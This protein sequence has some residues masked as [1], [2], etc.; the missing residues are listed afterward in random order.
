MRKSSALL[1]IASWLVLSVGAIPAAQ[2]AYSDPSGRVARLSDSSGEV[3]YSPAG[4]DQWYAISRNRPLTRGDRLWADRNGRAELQFGS[5]AVRL[6]AETSFAI[7]EFDDRIAQLQIT[8]GTLNIS[9]RRLYGGQSIEVATPTLAFVI[10]RAGRYRIDVDANDQLTTIQVWE[11][12]GEAYGGDGSR[13]PLRAGDVVRFYDSDLRDYEMYALP[14]SDSFDRYCLNRDR[15]LTQSVSLRYVD[16][17]LVG[18][19]DLDEYGSWSNAGDYGNVWYPNQVAANWAPYRDGH[20]VWQEPWGWTWVDD[21]PWGFAPSHYGRW[22]S[23]SGRWGW[24][25]GPRNVRRV[26]A[27]A[28]VAFVGGSDWGLSISV[29]GSSHTG[30]SRIGWFPL[31]PRDVYMPSYRTSREYFTQVNVSNTVVNNTTITTVYNNYASGNIN[32]AQPRYANRGIASALTAVPGDVFR[33]AQPVSRAML[34]VDPQSLA[35]SE[36]LNLAPLAPSARSVAGSQAA[37]VKPSPTANDRR[38]YARNAPPPV[39][40]PFAAREQQLQRKPGM[41]IEA[42]VKPS[43]QRQTA[44]PQ[45]RVIAAGTA[46]DARAAGSSRQTTVPGGKPAQLRTLDRSAGD[47]REKEPIGRNRD[48]DGDNRKP[49]TPVKDPQAQARVD[50]ERAQQALRAEQRQQAGPQRKDDD[51]QQV[52][53]QRQRDDDA[54]TQQ[55]QRQAEQAEQRKEDAQQRRRDDAVQAQQAQRQ[56]EQVEQRKEDAQQRQRD[57]AVQA[58]QAQRQAEQVEQRKEDAQQ[59]Q[60]DEAVQAQQAQQA[61][62]QAEQEAQRQRAKPEQQA[63]QEPQQP[64]TT[65]P[66]PNRSEGKKPAKGPP[67]QPADAEADEELDADDNPKP[68]KKRDQ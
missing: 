26:Y 49:S 23:I 5:A 53:Q 40:L 11:G 46:A 37:R 31:G 39:Q 67:K 13:F 16:D 4:E 25:P 63:P 7:L 51:Q 27:P 55:V 47:E 48:G 1:A 21:A 8:Q 65:P 19:A 45:V 3:S 42:Q 57:D 15:L 29:G 14:R 2:A 38:V 34:R 6:G 33:N 68:K 43:G 62:R 59:R 12:S 20:W 61:Q 52:Q 56:A 41:P 18:Y 28:L 50:A 66:G 36:I 35:S 58:Q 22:A 60:R 24:L 30:S 17:D 44:T 54:Q 32:T 64:P 9:V 10:D